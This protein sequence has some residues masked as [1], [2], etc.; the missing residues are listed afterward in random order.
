M[1][2]IVVQQHLKDCL[3]HG[4]CKHIHESIQYLYST[5]RTSSLQLMVQVVNKNEE[6]LDKVR[7]RATVTT[8]LGEG[9]AELWHQIAK[10]MA[11]LTKAVQGNNLSSVP[12]SPWERGHWRG[13]NG[14][15]TPSHPNSHNGRSSPGQ[16]TPACCLPIGYG[17]GGTGN[18]SNGQGNQGTSIRMESTANRHDPNSPQS[19]RC[20]GWGHMARE[21][22]TPVS[23]LN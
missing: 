3:F 19:F 8:E 2:D 4:V 10:L 21:C 5:P 18:G 20:Q 13:C 9:M 12:S 22:P 16:T 1:T 15:S 23:A 14:S 7:S 11:A 6:I 17:T